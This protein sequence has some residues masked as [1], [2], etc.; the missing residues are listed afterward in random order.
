MGFTGQ[1]G[2]YGAWR[3]LCAV[4]AMLTSAVQVAIVSALL[5]RYAVFGLVGWLLVGFVLLAPGA[6]R[7]TVQ[8]VYRFRAPE[9]AAGEWLESL[10]EWAEHRCRVPPGRLD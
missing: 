8:A 10:R 4:P 3:L 9:G 2:H 6:E 5:G 1:R 7:A